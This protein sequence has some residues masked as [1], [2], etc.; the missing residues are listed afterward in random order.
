MLWDVQTVHQVRVTGWD[1]SRRG[2]FESATSLINLPSYT[3]ASTVMEKIGNVRAIQLGTAA[4]IVF[5]AIF[6]RA[7]RGW[8]LYAAWVWYTISICGRCVAAHPSPSLPSGLRALVYSCVISAQ[9]AMT[10]IEASKAGLGQGELQAGLGGLD[11]T[12]H[13]KSHPGLSTQ[14]I[15]PPRRRGNC[16]GAALAPMVLSWLYDI[17]TRHG[18]PGSSTTSSP[19]RSWASS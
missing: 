15:F 8:H 17:G 2:V 11:A 3:I 18:S 12:S 10:M 7:S 5:Y 4:N 19:R 9:S 14:K 13:G 1:T 16:G 6:G